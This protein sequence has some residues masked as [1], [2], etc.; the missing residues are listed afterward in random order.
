MTAANDDRAESRGS[1]FIETHGCKLNQ[2][3]SQALAC[4]F[5]RAGYRLVSASDTADI[6]VVNTC[7][8]TRQ[9]TAKPARP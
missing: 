5:A 9:L 7:T 1:V 6:H 4:R 8:V 3:D 2:A